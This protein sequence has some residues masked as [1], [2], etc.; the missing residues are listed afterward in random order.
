MY[1][2]HLG[3]LKTYHIIVNFDENRLYLLY[4]TKCY[5]QLGYLFCFEVANI[6]DNKFKYYNLC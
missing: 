1:L 3:Y 2:A 4:R 6:K 5:R